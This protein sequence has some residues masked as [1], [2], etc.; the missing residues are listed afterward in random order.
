ML[1]PLA[2]FVD[3]ANYWQQGEY[4]YHVWFE[5]A[6]DKPGMFW[7]TDFRYISAT[8]ATAPASDKTMSGNVHVCVRLWLFWDLLLLL[9]SLG[10]DSAN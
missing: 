8:T 7:H 2:L 1:S 10:I 4:A 5:A 6:A 3:Q 9:G